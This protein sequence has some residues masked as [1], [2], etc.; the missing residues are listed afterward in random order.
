[1]SKLMKL[2]DIAVTKDSPANWFATAASKAAWERTLDYL[3][4]LG[5]VAQTALVVAQK[6]GTNASKFIYKQIWAG[7]NV[8]R[9][10]DIA[11]ETGRDKAKY[12]AWLC[13]REANEVRS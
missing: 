9:W 8:E 12:F 13:A 7:R 5:R 3:A 10:A 2:A 1:L 6:L 11:R 4:K